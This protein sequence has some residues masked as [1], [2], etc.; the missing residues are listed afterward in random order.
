MSLVEEMDGFNSLFP[1]VISNDFF[2]RQLDQCNSSCYQINTYEQI[3]AGQLPLKW[4][5]DKI[6]ITVGHCLSSC[7]TQHYAFQ[8]Y[9]EC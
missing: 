3:P 2:S 9:L 6:S 4:E 7:V 5:L 8:L 1:L